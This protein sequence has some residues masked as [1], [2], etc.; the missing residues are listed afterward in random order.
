MVYG[1]LEELLVVDFGAPLHC[2]ALCGEVHPL[3]LEVCMRI[4]Y[5]VI[6]LLYNSVCILST[7]TPY[8]S[9]IITIII[10][11]YYYYIATAIDVGVF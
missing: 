11:I 4:E 6:L 2:L 1:T 8:I 7:D 9:I 3:E 10:F 5:I